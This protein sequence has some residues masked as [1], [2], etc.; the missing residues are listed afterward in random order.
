MGRK[1]LRY[2]LSVY[3]SIS[4]LYIVGAAAA[5]RYDLIPLF[6]GMYLPVAVLTEVGLVRIIS[7]HGGVENARRKGFRGRIAVY[8]LEVGCWVAVASLMGWRRFVPIIL[9]VLFPSMILFD[10]L[11]IYRVLS[12]DR[13]SLPGTEIST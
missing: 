5:G 7:R 6:I 3:L 11:F 8:L 2:R 4:L 1:G 13:R 9:A 12:G 10:L